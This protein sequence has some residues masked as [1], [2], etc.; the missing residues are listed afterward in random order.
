MKR[1]LNPSRWLLAFAAALVLPTASA[2]ELGVDARPHV[3]V[4][5][6]AEVMVVPDYA[7]F[8][9]TVQHFDKE[10]AAVRTDNQSAVERLLNSVHRMGVAAADVATT[11]SMVFPDRWG[12][13]NCSDDEKKSGNTAL[14]KVTVTLR[15]MSQVSLL[16]DT[17]S[18]DNHVLLED[19]EY[20]T[21]E[22]RKHRDAARAMAIRA[23]REKSEALAQE[24]GQQ[25]GKALTIT[26]APSNSWDGSGFSSWSQW[27]YGCC[28][29]YSRYGSFQG[30]A[31]MQNSSVAAPGPAS[32]SGGDAGTLAPGRIAVR[33]HVSV[34][35]ELK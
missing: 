19:V 4:S 16:A 7:V 13:S 17:V 21:T 18:G 25:I 27:G 23:A 31:M 29:Y 15:D 34:V 1:R 28:G 33:A 6:D 22:L 11:P 10:V 9:L 5:G 8:R 30:N 3:S 32:A 35:F 2:D 26:E 14:T 24:L 20:R 12:C